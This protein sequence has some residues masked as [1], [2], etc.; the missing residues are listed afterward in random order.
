MRLHIEMDDEL[1]ERIDQTA[2]SRGR[3][4]F[5][6]NAVRDALDRRTRAELV[7]SARGALS[8]AEHPWDTDV[9]KWVRQQRRAD[10][11]RTG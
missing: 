9:A 2:G 11:K 8:E 1:V 7:H 6:R 5:I 4:D 10:T 3:S